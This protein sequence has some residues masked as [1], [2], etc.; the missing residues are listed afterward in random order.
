MTKLEK[1]MLDSGLTRQD[2]VT[3]TGISRVQIDRYMH[4]KVIHPRN[5]TLKLISD[6]LDLSEND[7]IKL[8]KEEIKTRYFINTETIR[9]LM[10]EKGLIQKQLA[11]LIGIPPQTMSFYVRNITKIS[12]ENLKKIAEILECEVDSLIDYE[13]ESTTEKIEIP[14]EEIV[15]TTIDNSTTTENV[16]SVRICTKCMFENVVTVLINSEF[17]YPADTIQK[18]ARRSICEMTDKLSMNYNPNMAA[19][20]SD[21][22][23]NFFINREKPLKIDARYFVRQKKDKLF[24][25]RDKRDDDMINH[26]YVISY[27]NR[28]TRVVMSGTEKFKMESVFRD[29][30]IECVVR[31]ITDILK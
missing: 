12:L 25:K 18:W 22:L 15:P 29:L 11:E 2:L 14:E 13:N 23:F 17:S 30:G 21:M 4:G 16:Q 26:E 9:N 28:S 3:L 7:V 8:M 1:H 19:L 27:N 20:I 5:K 24:L 31:D 10:N 6:A